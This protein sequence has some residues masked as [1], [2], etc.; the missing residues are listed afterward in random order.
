MNSVSAAVIAYNVTKK[1]LLWEQ[2]NTRE[3]KITAHSCVFSTFMHIVF[4]NHFQSFAFLFASL[5]RTHIIFPSC[6]RDSS[7]HSCAA[8]PGSKCANIVFHEKDRWKRNQDE[9]AHLRFGKWQLA[10]RFQALCL[11]NCNIF[12]QISHCMWVLCM[13]VCV[14]CLMWPSACSRNPFIV[15]IVSFLCIVVV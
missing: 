2:K 12:I 15:S 14:V 1:L 9:E 11:C 10:Y 7:V 8:R 5:A 13:C 4:S 6:K 3:G